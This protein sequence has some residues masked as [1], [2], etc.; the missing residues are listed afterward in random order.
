MKRPF[1]WL[2][3]ALAYAVFV[4]LVGYFSNRPAMQLIGEEEAV[5]RLS[6]SHV[7]ERIGECRR[8]TQEELNELP[9]NMRQSTDCPRG[10]LP[11]FVRLALDGEVV[12]E[13]RLPPSGFWGDGETAVNRK[14]PVRAGEHRL[15]VR[16]RDSDRE[17]GFD[18]SMSRTLD[19][20]P[21]ENVVIG[22]D[23]DEGAF[24][25]AG[26]QP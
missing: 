7:G 24:T 2:T 11:L 14:F 5:I 6:F 13:K 8:L 15:E 19:I 20:E 4:V 21:R 3:Q 10:R 12:F 26:R 25:I 17:S 1:R 22:F 16:M 23:A 9:P 18:H